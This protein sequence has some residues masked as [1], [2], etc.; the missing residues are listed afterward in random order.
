MDKNTDMGSSIS[1][2]LAPTVENSTVVKLK[3]K[4]DCIIPMETSM[5]EI[6]EMI[7]PMEMENISQAMEP[8]M[9]ANGKMIIDMDMGNK[10]GQMAHASRETISPTR[11]TA[12]GN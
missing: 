12:K 1:L 6:G 5:L 11:K 3:E 8:S 10:S 9:R 7:N 2:T 4:E